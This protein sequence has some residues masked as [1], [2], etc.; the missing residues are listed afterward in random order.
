MW[1]GSSSRRSSRELLPISARLSAWCCSHSLSGRTRTAERVGVRP[2]SSRLEWVSPRM[3]CGRFLGVSRSAISTRGCRS[4]SMPTALR[5]S[6]T[7]GGRRRSNCRSSRRGST[8]NLFIHSLLVIHPQAGREY[9]LRRF[10]R[11][12]VRPQRRDVSTAKAGREYR[13][14]LPN[15]KETNSFAANPVALIHRRLL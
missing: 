6:L 5:C 14:V 4:L 2:V 8:P 15:P 13:P 11:R 3:D 12:D 7:R 9:R 1:R 10:Q